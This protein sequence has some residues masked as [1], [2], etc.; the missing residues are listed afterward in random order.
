[1]SRFVV[2]VAIATGTAPSQWW[3]E[4]LSTLLTAVEVLEERAEAMKRGR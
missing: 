3:G 4:D 1:M 2:E